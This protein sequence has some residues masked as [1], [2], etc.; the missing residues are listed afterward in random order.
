MKCVTF[1]QY[2][3]NTRE[4]KSKQFLFFDTLGEYYQ[5]LYIITIKNLFI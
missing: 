5:K 3:K 2:P 4:S 1:Q